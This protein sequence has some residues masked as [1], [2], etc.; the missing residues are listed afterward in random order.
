MSSDGTRHR[1]GFVSPILAGLVAL[2]SQVSQSRSSETAAE[3]AR[4]VGPGYEVSDVHVGNTAR[5]MAGL[6]ATALVVIASMIWLR[7]TVAAHQRQALPSL[8]AQQTSRLV[9]PPPNLQAD[10]YADLDA[11]R[12]AE[13]RRLDGYAYIDAARQR[14]RIPLDRAMAL[15]VGRTLD[16]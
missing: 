7:A 6:M 11:Q 16:P 4:S 9:P 13:I 14:A 8:T 5:V 10:P 15:T 12:T 2:R 3:T 1:F